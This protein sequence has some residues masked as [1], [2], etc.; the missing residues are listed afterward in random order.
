M[1]TFEYLERIKKLNRL[2]RSGQ[3]G[4]PSELAAIMGISQSHLFRCL[5]EL[6]QYGME[7]QYSRSLKTYYYANDNEL[8]IFYSLQLIAASKTKEIMGGKI[9]L[10]ELQNP[11]LPVRLLQGYI[12]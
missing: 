11:T 5:K 8:T 12:S 1:K 9:L 7:I 4:T 3:T 6:E 2:I 10:N